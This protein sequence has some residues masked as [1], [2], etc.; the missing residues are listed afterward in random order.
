[1]TREPLNATP[2][3]ANVQQEAE[4]LMLAFL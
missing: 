1:L 4:G 3:S 2:S